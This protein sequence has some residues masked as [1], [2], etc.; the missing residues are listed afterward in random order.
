MVFAAWLLRARCCSLAAPLSRLTPPPPPTPPQDNDKAVDDL[1]RDNALAIVK[2][3]RLQHWFGEE[4]AKVYM[5]NNCALEVARITEIISAHALRRLEN[6]TLEREEAAKAAQA[7]ARMAAGL[8]GAKR[9]GLSLR[10]R[11]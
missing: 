4:A 9:A 6:E 11:V 2:Q 7:A 10:A 1:Y 3:V 5:R 8:E